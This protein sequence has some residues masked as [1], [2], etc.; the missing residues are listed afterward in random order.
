M[1]LPGLASLHGESQRFF[2]IRQRR[3]DRP[4][5]GVEG[6]ILRVYERVYFRKPGLE[7]VQ[8]AFQAVGLATIWVG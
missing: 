3:M 4:Q 7:F 5:L 2:V 1:Y 8:L 6:W